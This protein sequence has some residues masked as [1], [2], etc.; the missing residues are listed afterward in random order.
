MLIIHLSSICQSCFTDY[1]G[2]PHTFLSFWCIDAHFFGKSSAPVIMLIMLPSNLTGCRHDLPAF[3]QPKF[4]ISRDCKYVVNALLRSCPKVHKNMASTKKLTQRW[5]EIWWSP[6]EVSSS[7]HY[8]KCFID[9]YSYLRCRIFRTFTKFIQIQKFGLLQVSHVT[10][11]SSDIWVAKERWE[12]LRANP[13]HKTI[14]ASTR[15]GAP[16]HFDSILR[17]PKS[18]QCWPSNSEAPGKSVKILQIATEKPMLTMPTV[19]MQLAKNV[20]ICTRR[21]GAHW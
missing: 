3:P 6:V 17:K 19:H 18:S 16:C 15:L 5:E 1:P 9:L 14:L 11:F 8:S 20:E 2:N 21:Q 10:I 7:A 12:V 13:W 4:Y